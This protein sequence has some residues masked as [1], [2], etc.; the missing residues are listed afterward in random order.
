[1]S[2]IIYGPQACGKTRNAEKLRSHF[3]MDEVADTDATC[4][5]DPYPISAKQVAE[6]KRGKIL[7]LTNIDP[8]GNACNLHSRRVISFSEAMEQIKN[9]TQH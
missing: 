6:F 2:I 9:G 8:R 7:F 3:K 4:G 1:M 5:A